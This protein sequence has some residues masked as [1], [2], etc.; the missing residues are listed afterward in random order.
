[1]YS[2]GDAAMVQLGQLGSAYL[3]T[4]GTTFTPS[5]GQVVV[6]VTM[7]TDCGFDK[8]T[9]EGGAGTYFGIGGAGAGGDTLVAAD[10]FPAGMTI[11]GRWTNVSVTTTGQK[12][13][14]YI[15]D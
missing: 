7:I 8:L 4:D 9:A 15:G 5:G 13:I 14:C 6:A 12:C 2:L 11:Y 1:M 3:D 10:E